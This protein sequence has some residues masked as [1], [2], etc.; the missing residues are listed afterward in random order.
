MNTG[1]F[2]ESQFAALQKKKNSRWALMKRQD[3][4][5]NAE[6]VLTVATRRAPG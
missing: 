3:L 6:G 4:H 2:S 5:T 1:L